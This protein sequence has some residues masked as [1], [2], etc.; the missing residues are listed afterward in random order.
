MLAP[1]SY[2]TS[3]LIYA[4]IRTRTLDDSR[5]AKRAL[6]NHVGDKNIQPLRGGI[7]KG[8]LRDVD[9]HATVLILLGASSWLVKGI[10]TLDA[11]G[12]RHIAR[13]ISDLFTIGLATGTDRSGSR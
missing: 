3:S 13:E 11:A 4:R 1:Y 6:Y 8:S 9:L 5:A 10:L 7:K 12:L 2:F